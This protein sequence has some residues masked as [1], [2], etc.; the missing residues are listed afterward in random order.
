MPRIFWSATQGIVLLKIDTLKVS[1]LFLLENS[2]MAHLE[3]S[4][5]SF[6]SLHHFSMEFMVSVILRWRAGREGDE[7]MRKISSA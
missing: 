7:Q 2:M 1:Q 3:G 4:I 5:F 6:Q